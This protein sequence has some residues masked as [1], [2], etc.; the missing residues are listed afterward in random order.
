MPTS[1]PGTLGWPAV[2]RRS[3]RLVPST[4]STAIR[5]M[6]SAWAWPTRR[7]LE[8]VGARSA[9]H[10]VQS[11]IASVGSWRAATPDPPA[12][13]QYAHPERLV[14]ADWL[15]GAPRLP[16]PWRSSSPTRTCRSTTSATSR[17]VKIDWHT[18]QRSARSGLHQRRKQFAEPMNRKGH[19]ARRHRGDL[20]RQEQLVGGLRAVGVHLRASLMSGC[21][22]AGDA[23]PAEG[24]RQPH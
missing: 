22:T 23:W 7:L 18:D 20:R 12:L 3:G 1:P 15:S 11:G 17:A 19:F 21:S 24:A 10:E 5:P 4:G 16:W 9:N 13:Q 8:S 6:S 14:T 2:H